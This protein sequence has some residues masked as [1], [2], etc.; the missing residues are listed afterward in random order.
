MKKAIFIVLAIMICGV[1]FAGIKS[2]YAVGTYE[3]S[4]W[5]GSGTKEVR[6]RFSYEAAN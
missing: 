4:S 5:T 1:A 2:R 6:G 3:Q